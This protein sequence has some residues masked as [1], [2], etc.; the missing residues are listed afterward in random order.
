MASAGGPEEDPRSWLTHQS[1]ENG[2]LELQQVILSQKKTVVEV[3]GK[4]AQ[5]LKHLPLKSEDLST[6]PGLHISLGEQQLLRVRGLHARAVECVYIG[7]TT[8]AD[9]HTQ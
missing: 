5:W 3:G 7:N 1:R 6:I 9:V 4:V 8:N 2:A